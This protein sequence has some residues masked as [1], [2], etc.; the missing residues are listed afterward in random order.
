MQ[1]KSLRDDLLAE[2]NVNF[3]KKQNKGNFSKIKGSNLK[4]DESSIPSN[5]KAWY[6]GEGAKACTR[7]GSP[8][9]HKFEHC[10]AFNATF[11][12]KDDNDNFLENFCIDQISSDERWNCKVAVHKRIIKLLQANLFASTWENTEEALC[13]RSGDSSFRKYSL[14]A[15]GKVSHEEIYVVKILHVSLLSAKASEELEFIQRLSHVNS[16]PLMDPLKDYPELFSGLGKL[17]KA[18]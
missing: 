10:P 18:I 8:T 14:E 6:Q 15:N 5:S 9:F 13:C 11:T 12:S 1:Q 3:V 2:T 16:N 17:N 7:C 4:H